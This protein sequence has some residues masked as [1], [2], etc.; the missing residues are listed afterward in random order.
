MM[1][2]KNL[3]L[4]SLINATPDMYQFLK[5]VIV[6]KASVLFVDNNH[7]VSDACL[8]FAISCLPAGE[9]IVVL[10]PKIEL[11]LEKNHPNKNLRR[12]SY[13]FDSESLQFHLTSAIFRY[14]DTVFLSELHSSAEVRALIQ[15]VNSGH[16]VISRYSNSASDSFIHSLI[17]LYQESSA[18]LSFG[19]AAEVIANAIDIIALCESTTTGYQMRNVIELE[20]SEGEPVVRTIFENQRRI[21]I[22]SDKLYS[23]NPSQLSR[24]KQVGIE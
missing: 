16:Q 8:E 14:C 19:D 17:R 1:D 7:T 5:D 13:G 6:S 23:K 22:I 12:I 4:S 2:K 11:Q 3:Q 18:G 20:V 15:A 9:R 21:N 24:W 10:E